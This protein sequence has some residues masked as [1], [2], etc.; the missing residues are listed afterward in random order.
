MIPSNENTQSSPR[1]H[2]IGE[3]NIA[4]NIYSKIIPYVSNIKKWCSVYKDPINST[5]IN[6][7]AYRETF[8]YTCSMLYPKLGF[9]IDALAKLYERIAAIKNKR[10]MIEGE[11]ENIE[12][13]FDTVCAQIKINQSLPLGNKIMLVYE[14]TLKYAD[15]ECGLFTCCIETIPELYERHHTDFPQSHDRA[16][17]NLLSLVKFEEPLDQTTIVNNIRTKLAYLIKEVELN[18][19]LKPRERSSDIFNSYQ[20]LCQTSDRVFYKSKYHINFLYTDFLC[21]MKHNPSFGKRFTVDFIY[22][23]TW[24]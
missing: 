10:N 12:L 14:S 19:K 21:K 15:I 13:E 5:F 8:T 18:M 1:Q 4:R 6:D 9:I 2:S 7:S 22:I 16:I 23:F 17:T 3:T 24:D 11:Q 20:Q